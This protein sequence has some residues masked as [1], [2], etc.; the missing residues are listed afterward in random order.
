[1]RQP[2]HQVTGGKDPFVAPDLHKNRW[3]ATTRTIDVTFFCAGLPGRLG[4]IASRFGLICWPL[5][6]GGP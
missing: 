6:D 5:S 4:R 1:M 2:K 3:P